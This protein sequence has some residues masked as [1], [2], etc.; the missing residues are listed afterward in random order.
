MRLFASIVPGSIKRGWRAFR[1]AQKLASLGNAHRISSA[2]LRLVIETYREMKANDA[3]L[4][5]AGVAYYAVL[6]LVPLA[7]AL[8]GI[9][10]LFADSE[11]V[12]RAVESF[13]AVYLPDAAAAIV[14]EFESSDAGL[15]GALGVVGL[16][17]LLWVGSAMFSAISKTINKAFAISSTRPFYLARP[18]ALALGLGLFLLFAISV[19][20]SLAIESFANFSIPLVSEQEFIQVVAHGPPLLLTFATFTIAYKMLPNTDTK[21]TY[22]LPVAAVVT[23]VFEAAKFGFAIYLNRYASYDAVYGA[24]ASVVVLMVW[25]YTSAYIVIIGA[26]V[27]AV[28][29]RIREHL[30]AGAAAELSGGKSR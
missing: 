11:D 12:T 6:S 7:L 23:V 8:W 20:S 22:I 17:S 13:F 3:G 9:L 19:Y 2:T 4:M 18:R 24:I 1:R 28:Y 26:H 14:D 16:L 25:S 5:A 27:A 29:I 21:W 15:N 10:G 30:P